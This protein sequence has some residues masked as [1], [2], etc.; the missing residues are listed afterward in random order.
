MLKYNFLKLRVE[1]RLA[2]DGQ[3]RVAELYDATC[4]SDAIIF[5]NC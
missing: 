1:V 4:F 2:C 3:T 5:I